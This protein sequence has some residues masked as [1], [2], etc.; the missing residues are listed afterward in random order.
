MRTEGIQARDVLSDRRPISPSDTVLQLLR[1]N[2][3]IRLLFCAQVI[4][5]A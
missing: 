5:S 3:D 2:R 1:N 4:S